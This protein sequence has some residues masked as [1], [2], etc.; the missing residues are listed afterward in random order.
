MSLRVLVLCDPVLPVPPPG[1]GGIERI[2]ADLIAH[3][4][5][6]GHSV[7]LIAHPD[8]NCAVEKLYTWPGSAVRGR[9]DTWHNLHAVRR[10]VRDFRPDVVQSFA[11][12]AYLAGILRW[13]VAKVMSYQRHTGGRALG[14]C[15][16]AAGRT[17]R[18]TGCSEFISSQGRGG[19]GVWRTIYNFTDLDRS[20]F[21]PAVAPDAPLVFLSRVESIKGADRAVA[22]ARA[23][24]RQLIIA[25][26]HA[27][28]GAE[29][30]YWE[31]E[32]APHLGRN[33]I[34]YI[35]EV[36]DAQ[37]RELLGKAAALIVPIRWDEPFGIV[38][39]EA[40]ASG[41]PVITCARGALPEIIEAGRTGF[42]IETTEDGVAAV[43]RLHE[44]DRRECR[45]AA[46]R[47]F[48]APV[49]AAQYLELY[50]EMTP[51]TG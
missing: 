10:A 36:N 7:A 47:R 30:R 40:L 13:P 28:E 14:I 2:A 17:L 38:F 6:A 26:N 8:S 33:R 23:S 25:G 4:R 37:K 5:A 42:F 21:Q 32:I 22:I 51:T 39:A 24:D 49:C 35:G 27:S 3:F 41:T 11:R 1:Y 44:I 48:S 12:L 19:G 45:A 50:Q 46:E 31:T 15:A 43:R 34:E 9:R 20:S 18:F 29:A 16:A